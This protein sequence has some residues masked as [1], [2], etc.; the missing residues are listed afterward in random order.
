M[1]AE[2]HGDDGCSWTRCGLRRLST[3]ARW[4]NSISVTIESWLPH[5]LL[6]L[7]RAR[8]V[9]ET[10]ARSGLAGIDTKLLGKPND[11]HGEDEKWFEWATVFRG[12]AGAAVPF[13]GELVNLVETD[14]H[15]PHANLALT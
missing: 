3:Q 6:L 7:R 1:T 10:T 4:R 2:E 5:R 12:Y 15:S 14:R 9:A 11:F 13:V 8:K